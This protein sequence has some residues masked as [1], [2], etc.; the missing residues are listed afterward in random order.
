MASNPEHRSAS[1]RLGATPAGG[2]RSGRWHIQPAVVAH[3]NELLPALR[4]T[5][6]DKVF[7]YGIVVTRGSRFAHLGM[8]ADGGRGWRQRGDS[9][10]AWRRWRRAPGLLQLN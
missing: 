4:F 2:R 7:T 5:K 8:A 9:A 3:R 6:L 1:E 10:Q